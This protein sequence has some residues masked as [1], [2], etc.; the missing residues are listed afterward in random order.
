MGPKAEARQYEGRAA[1]EV[2]QMLEPEGATEHHI[3]SYEHGFV[4]LV[5]YAHFFCDFLDPAPGILKRFGF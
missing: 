1:G 3:T 5:S 2:R 4:F